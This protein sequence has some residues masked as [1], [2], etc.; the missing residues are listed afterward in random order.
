MNQNE[1]PSI[2]NFVDQYPVVR[3][4]PLSRFLW[5]C[6]GADANILAVCPNSDR[7]KYEGLG[8]VVLSTG[9]LALMSG[10]YAF[11]TVFGA[12][13]NAAGDPVAVPFVAL[14]A[15]TAGLVWA[16]VIFNIDRFI[17]SSS[18]PGDGTDAI[19]LGELGKGIPRILMATI[20]GFCLSKPLEIR[21][22]Q[23][24]IDGKLQEERA[25]E[26]ER[27]R[28]VRVSEIQRE[29]DQHVGD[30]QRQIV[31][32]QNVGQSRTVQL[33][34]AEAIR[35]RQV[36]VV[37]RETMGDPGSSGH[38]GIGPRA[39]ALR[40]ELDRRQ[41]DVQRLDSSVA[42]SHAQ[43]ETI[44]RHLAEARREYAQREE[45][46]GD[47]ARRDAR[48][49]VRD[50]LLRRILLAHE[51]SAWG[52][53]AITLLLLMIELGPIFFKMMLIKGTYDY[54]SDDLKRVMLARAG[55]QNVLAPDPVNPGMVTS[56]TRHHRPVH[57]FTVKKLSLEK[58]EELG[59]I[60]VESRS[61]QIKGEIRRNPGSYVTTT[62]RP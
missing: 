29:R 59:R 35:N 10:S 7:V 14:K 23:A 12:S 38:A 42:A 18:G 17:V 31:E 15:F 41:A 36:D 43:L 20:I 16:I 11:Y 39:I 45:R 2:G 25:S 56:E 24:E 21:V 48:T 55:I 51:I 32:A 8:G 30:M 50:G 22:F 3:A 57:E 54:L 40:E 27:R 61:E 13:V 37:N 19:T 6:A 26:A 49:M 33:H 44:E 28:L 46:A 53:W 52:T 47:I 4:N 9:I 1:P 60:A 62:E 5:W 34:E 58:E